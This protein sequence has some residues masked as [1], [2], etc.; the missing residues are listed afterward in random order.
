MTGLTDSMRANF[1]PMKKMSHANIPNMLMQR[2]EEFRN[3]SLFSMVCG[4]DVYHKIGN[5]NKSILA[6]TASMNKRATQYWSGA[7]IQDEGQEIGNSLEDLMV[8]ALTEFKKKNTVSLQCHSLQGLS[9]PLP[10]TIVDTDVVAP[11]TSN[12]FLVSQISRQ[13]VVSPTDYVIDYDNTGRDAS[14]IQQLTYKLCYTYYNVAGSI[15]VPASIQYA[16]RLANL[17]GDRAKGGNLASIPNPH[18]HFGA[19][20]KSLYFIGKPASYYSIIKPDFNHDKLPSTT[21]IANNGDCFLPQKRIL[22]F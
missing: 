11:D 20:V 1:Q 16:H 12:F 19:N 5:G 10:G 6:F 14:K 7:K 8:Q 22:N 4:I 17:I 2:G 3:A 21:I 9:N 15:K 18:A 13:R